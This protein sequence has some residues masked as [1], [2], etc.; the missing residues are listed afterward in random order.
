M[1]QQMAAA[2]PDALIEGYEPLVP[3][4]TNHPKDRHVLAAAARGNAGLI[5]T[6][7]VK[8]FPESAFA[9]YDIE[10]QTADELLSYAFGQDLSRWSG[11]HPGRSRPVPLVPE[12]DLRHGRGGHRDGRRGPLGTLRAGGGRGRGRTGQPRRV[13]RRSPAG[14]SCRLSLAEGRFGPLVPD[15]SQ[16]GVVIRGRVRCSAEAWVVTVFLVSDQEEQRV[17]KDEARLFQA[18]VAVSSPAGEA[19]F[20]RPVGLERGARRERRG[21]GPGHGLPG[22]RGAGRRARDRGARLGGRLRSPTGLAPFDEGR[23][24]RRGAPHRR[25]YGLRGARA[26]RG[27]PGHGR[28]GP[29]RRLRAGSGAA[30]ARGAYRSWTA[31]QRARISAPEACRGG[32][33]AVA[34]DGLAAASGAAACSEAGIDLLDP[35]CADHDPLAGASP[36]GH[37]VPAG[38]DARRR[39]PPGRPRAQ[40]GRRPG[41]GRRAREPPL[42]AVPL[43]FL[44]LNLPSLADPR[45]RER[46]RGDQGLVDLLWF[47]TGRG[48]TGAYLGR[49]AFTLAMRRLQ[50]H[51]GDHDGSDGVGVLIGC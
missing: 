17:N 41:P 16:P 4:M 20:R 7:N 8:D 29:G 21:Q 11:P 19:L 9:S 30:P 10:V 18:Q 37:V 38:A 50:G 34:G 14:G 15:S 3:I 26:G 45:H 47:P 48:K 49:A 22:P 39:G 42:A 32:F 24:C 5:V 44:L 28:T 1:R 40:L 12:H 36:T 25:P 46:G 51:H 27:D 33:E 6:E 31:A 43:G 35:A 23:A 2:F 13:W